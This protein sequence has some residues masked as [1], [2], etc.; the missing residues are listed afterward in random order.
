MVNKTTEVLWNNCLEQFH[1][2]NRMQGTKFSVLY[3]KSFFS[4][5]KE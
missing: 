5:T 4:S 3:C 1:K 2:G